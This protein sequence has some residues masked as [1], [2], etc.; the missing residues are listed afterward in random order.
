MLGGL[1]GSGVAA[2]LT[3]GG[4]EDPKAESSAA[5]EMLK[6][7]FGHGSA[8]LLLLVTTRA[9]VDD[10]AV[11]QA[12]LALTRQVAREPGV[13][14]VGSYW[15]ERAAPL[16]S[17]DRTHALVMG[18]ILGNEDEVSNRVKQ[19]VASYTRSG[20]QLDIAVG[21]S[22]AITGQLRDT[23]D[24]DHARAEAIAFPILL[25]LL[26]FVFGSVV[27]ALLPLAVGAIAVVGT[28]AV[29]Q[30]LTGVTDVSVYALNLATGLGLG[31]AIDYSLF[32]VSRFREELAA[33]LAVD[34][35]VVRTMRTAGRTVA[36]SGAT[37]AISLSALLIFPQVFMRSFAYAGIAVVG[38]A[39]VGALVVLPA[40]L[41]T[42]GRKVDAF[43][44]LRRREGSTSGG[45][46]HRIAVAVIR[47][48]IPVATGALAVLLL[49]GTPLLHVE[50]GGVDARVLPA[51]NQ[52]RLVSEQISG[53]FAAGESAAVTVVLPNRGPKEGPNKGDAAAD[54]TRIAG[55]AEKLS[56][57][58]GVARVD[59]ST[60]S[61]IAGKRVAANPTSASQVGT[62]GTWLSVVPAVEPISPAARTLLADL[63]AIDPPS[64]RVFVGGPSAEFFD[65][66]QSLF[67]LLPVAIGIVAVVTFILLFLMFGSLLVPTIA[68]LL[69]LLSLT[70][71]FGATVWVFQDGHL[72][73]LLD[74]TATGTLNT[75]I[76]ILMFC[77]AFGVSMDYG[78]F[79]LSR[80]REEY[81]RT[82]DNTAAV[83]MGFARTGGI[84]TAAAVLLATVLVVFATSGVTLVK[85]FGVGLALAVVVDVTLV[86]LCLVPAVMKLAGPANW[87][88]PRPL[89]R[90]HQR[91]KISEIPGQVLAP[92]TPDFATRHPVPT[93]GSSQPHL[94]QP[95]H[96]GAE[97]VEDAPDPPSGAPE[98]ARDHTSAQHQQ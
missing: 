26:L 69:S 5:A 2:K 77:L 64:D 48:P 50:F 84:V 79:I 15:S 43:R 12:G 23:I 96:P 80:I 7:D 3:S 94:E 24:A 34:Q 29:L 8:N 53:N 42:L 68:I 46:W 16:A 81:D 87:W 9:G 36:F 38:V 61:Y 86:R 44:I 97:S 85:L 95:S 93:R 25:V 66:Q 39:M 73:G 72:S 60:G 92:S 28:L 11:T 76:P 83:E 19:L 22:A 37:V 4:F 21:G 71:M 49:L 57:V 13:A 65:S 47:R 91:F 62:G 75:N 90:V 63:R 59:A 54:A 74:I 30:L 14:D 41:A 67:R 78:V 31:L 89:R 51:S 70:A 27:A 52:A 32:I 88:L 45:R 20:G 56:Q 55:Y 1:F 35:A 10:P 18:R 6:H 33:G 17:A 98:P 40:L 82:G 58:R